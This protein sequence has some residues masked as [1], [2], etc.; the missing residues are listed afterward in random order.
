[1]EGPRVELRP[2]APADRDDLL[3]A[4]RRYWL[5]LMPR[6]HGN[7]D[8]AHQAAYFA[9]RFRLDDAESAHWW[10]V[11]GGARIGFAKVDLREDADGRWADWRDFF[12][13]AEY[14]RQGHGTA[15]ARAAIAWLRERGY[16][17]VD[18]NVRQ[19]NPR[20][21]AFWRSI[22]FELASYRLRTYL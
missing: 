16:H 10:A 21:L 19:D 1:V 18:L 9:D 6:W 12:V 13:E 2:I 17:R 3:A 15:F 5:D 22:G 11:A 8:P 7:R 4:A 20:A 14:R